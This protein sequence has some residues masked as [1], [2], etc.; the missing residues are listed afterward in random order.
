MYFTLKEALLKGTMLFYTITAT[1]IIVGFS[2]VVNLSADGS[3][4]TFFGNPMRVSAHMKLDDVVNFILYSLEG[5][6]AQ[7]IMLFGIFATA[8]LIPSMI[9]KGSVEIY[10]SKPISRPVL[11][12]SRVFGASLGISLNV[13]YFILGIFIVLGV[14]LGIWHWGFLASSLV[15]CFSFFCY[16]SITALTGLI[17]RSG[18]LAIMFTFLSVFAAGPLERRESLLYLLWNNDIY[19]R[20]L[21]G[22]YYLLPQVGEMTKHSLKLIGTLPMDQNPIPFTIVPFL[23]SLGAAL[24]WYGISIWYFEKQDY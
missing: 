10:L 22:L 24:F 12:T 20:V 16:F 23:T 11:F 1:L 15:I 17:S 2:L 6:A 7:S 14:K 4:L 19:H 13:I 5:G 3:T 21:D 8:G 18:G 9:D